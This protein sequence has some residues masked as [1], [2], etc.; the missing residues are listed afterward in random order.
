M[1]LKA[2]SWPNTAACLAGWRKV[3]QQGWFCT[4][5]IVNAACPEGPHHL[6]WSGADLFLNVHK[7]ASWATSRNEGVA[8]YSSR[9]VLGHPGPNLFSLLFHKLYKH[10][11]GNSIHL[12]PNSK[13]NLLQWFITI[14]PLTLT[15]TCPN[16]ISRVASHKGLCTVCKSDQWET[17]FLWR[18][19]FPETPIGLETGL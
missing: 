3:T 19:A 16:I 7:T 4:W 2:K 5:W 8:W 12:Q 14:Y 9:P 1:R 6:S 17:E 11:S 18:T 15:Q 13:S 10:Y